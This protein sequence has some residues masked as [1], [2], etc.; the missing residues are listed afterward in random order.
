[1]EFK[2]CKC[3]AV[4]D[5]ELQEEQIKVGDF[6]LIGEEQAVAIVARVGMSTACLINLDTGNRRLDPIEV[7]GLPSLRKSDIDEMTTTRPWRKLT[8]AE[9][10]ARVADGG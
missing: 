8:R 6:L 1:M 2:C 5:I 4:H 7:F 10:A 3:G 9:A